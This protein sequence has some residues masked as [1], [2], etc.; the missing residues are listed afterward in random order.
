MQIMYENKNNCPSLYMN[1]KF[2]KQFIK[3]ERITLN[4]YVCKTFGGDRLFLLRQD[5]PSLTHK[6]SIPVTRKSFG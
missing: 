6:W 1:P 5:R 3:A 2:R 4:N